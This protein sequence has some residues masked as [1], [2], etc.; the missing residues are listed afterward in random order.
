MKTLGISSIVTGKE[1][2]DLRRAIE[3]LKEVFD[4]DRLAIVGGGKIN[5]GFL[6]E[7]LID[8]LSL[9]IGPGIDGRNNQPTLFDGITDKKDFLP[10]QLDFKEVSTFPNGVVWL[11]YSL[12]SNK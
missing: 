3:I 6:Q 12:N 10:V 4:V 8:E 11:R 2:I 9:M 5:G 7:G 1:K